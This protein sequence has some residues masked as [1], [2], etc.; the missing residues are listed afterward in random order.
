M[1][2]VKTA[3]V[4]RALVRAIETDVIPKVTDQYA[5]SQLWATTGILGNVAR[6]L[7]RPTESGLTPSTGAD[8]G[9]YLRSIG[10]DHAVEGGEGAAAAAALLRENLGSVIEGHATL[11]YRR[12]VAGFDEDS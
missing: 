10:L 4:L 1:D 3:D 12:A 9:A 7:E 6:E 2:Y 5:T 8:V 11:H